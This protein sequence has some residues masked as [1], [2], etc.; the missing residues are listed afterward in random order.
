VL[1]ASVIAEK[2]MPHNK[3]AYRAIIRALF[4]T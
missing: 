4:T 1:P 2:I 3:A